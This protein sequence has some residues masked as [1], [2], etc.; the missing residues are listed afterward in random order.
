MNVRFTDRARKVME[1]ANQEARRL[2][3]E[4]IGT[5]H[6]LLG[7]IQEGSGVAAHA[8]KNLNV[9]LAEVRR[10]VE[11]IVVAPGQWSVSGR[12][13]ETPR[14]KKVIE[15]AI[16]EADNLHHGYVGTEHILLGLIRE[17]EG[18]AGQVLINMH[19]SLKS[20]RA[21]VLRLLGASCDRPPLSESKP[22]LPSAPLRQSLSL[23][24]VVLEMFQQVLGDAVANEHFDFAAN[25]RNERDKLVTVRE[26]LRGQLPHPPND[27]PK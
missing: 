14:A 7:L 8:L 2:Q 24:D 1:L 4:Y 21:E 23:L 22:L 15:Y 5:E 3:H 6:I 18:V 27:S 16:E 26:F 25:L 11:M 10:Q 13:P 19:L 12:L 9:E 20:V 17:E